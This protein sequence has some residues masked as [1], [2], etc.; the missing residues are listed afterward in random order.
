ML[1]VLCHSMEHNVC[2]FVVVWGLSF[3][4]NAAMLECPRAAV[5]VGILWP[6]GNE[7]PLPLLLF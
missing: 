4:R 1:H 6:V 5:L 7:P 3:S 2:F